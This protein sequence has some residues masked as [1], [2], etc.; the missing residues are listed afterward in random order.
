MNSSR[1]STNGSFT[2]YIT[3]N[4]L[5]PH[6]VTHLGP[7]PPWPYAPAVQYQ[8]PAPSIQDDIDY[9]QQTTY[10]YQPNYT[11]P[12]VATSGK[13]PFLAFRTLVLM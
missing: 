8:Q 13:L 4:A 2:N 12:Q 6:S 11:P 3:Y 10:P 5:Y 1:P 9:L 7:L